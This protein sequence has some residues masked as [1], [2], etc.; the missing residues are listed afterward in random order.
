[1]FISHV[2]CVREMRILVLKSLKPRDGFDNALAL[3]KDDLWSLPSALS[4]SKEHWPTVTCVLGDLL[5][6]LF[7]SSGDSLHC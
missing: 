3:L 2:A 6:F 1:M 7:A 5:Y 4:A